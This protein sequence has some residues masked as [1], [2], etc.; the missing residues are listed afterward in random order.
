M[1]G[2]LGWMNM[3]NELTRLVMGTI[4]LVYNIKEC[5]STC[6]VGLP[7]TALIINSFLQNS[8]EFSQCCANICL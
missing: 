5:G 8:D 6:Y 3:R 7:H 4:F 1:K 2:R